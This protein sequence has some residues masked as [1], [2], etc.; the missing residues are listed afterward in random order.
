MLTYFLF[1]GSS[2]SGALANDPYVYSALVRLC[3]CVLKR[4]KGLFPLAGLHQASRDQI[5][6]NYRIG[7]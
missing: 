3:K 6:L 5:K 4:S 7:L 1:N 2:G